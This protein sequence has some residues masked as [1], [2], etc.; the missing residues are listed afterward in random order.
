MSTKAKEIESQS[1]PQ[2]E[3]ELEE[4][5]FQPTASADAKQRR[6]Q[7]LK[8][9]RYQEYPRYKSKDLIGKS[10]DLLD[11]VRGQIT[12]VD[13]TT[14]RRETKDVVTFI[15]NVDGAEFQ[16]TKPLNGFTSTYLDYFESFESG[17]PIEAMRGYTFV[18]EGEPVSGNKP[19]ILR[20]LA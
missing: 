1:Q 12:T 16:T 9:I 11:A 19:V 5:M 18:E 4:V 6:Q 7:A 15:V 8:A 13:K 10:F 2:S 17:E 20:K 3:P 14:G